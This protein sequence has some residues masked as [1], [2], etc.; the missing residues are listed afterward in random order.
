MWQTVYIINTLRADV[1]S[2]IILKNYN[3]QKKKMPPCL[4]IYKNQK[5][6]KQ[7]KINSSIK[8]KKEKKST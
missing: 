7:N 6:T 4:K 5:N 1:A 3:E 2:K 8:S